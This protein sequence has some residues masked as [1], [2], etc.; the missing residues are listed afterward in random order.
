MV[1]TPLLLLV[2]LVVLLLGLA[3]G[4]AWE[5]YK[6]QDGVWVDRRRARESPHYM[7]GLNFLV[8]SQVDQAI[9]ELSKAA[10]AAGD[11]LEI[12]LILGN[13]YREKGQVGRAIQ[14]HQ[15]LLQRPKLRRLEHANVMLC[16]GLDYRSGGFVDRA[17][18]AFNEVLK[19][20]PDNRYALSNLEKLH[21]DQH[22]WE[23]AYAARQRLAALATAADGGSESPRHNE[24]LAF[25]ENEFGQAALRGGDIQAAA[26][27]FDAAIERDPHNVPAH[28]YL[29]DVR[30]K[31]GRT[32]DAIE[33][34]ERLLDASPERVYL[35][36]SRLETAYASVGMPERFPAL[37]QRLIS[38]NSQ[39]WRARLALARHLAGQRQHPEALKLLFDALVVNPHSLAL[40]QAIWETLSALGLPPPLVSRYVEL[41]R[42]AVFYL[43]PHV[44]VRCRYRSTELL[45][46]CPHCH[47][48]NT[49]VEERI[50]PAKENTDL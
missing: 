4:K 48:W 14:E 21:E 29:G 8:A 40:H 42:D 47:E 18:E 9:D 3:V 31:E 19:L 26:R 11:P 46:Q 12:H 30:L 32:A 5:R 45:W 44:C 41:T 10:K 24:V 33:V 36:F 23:Q 7:L 2:A 27:R 28:L 13:L 25:L 35:A 49:F 39:N 34:W 50:A 37:C 16:L 38:S 43:D 15:S 20:D 17:I 22:Q 1:T 6:L